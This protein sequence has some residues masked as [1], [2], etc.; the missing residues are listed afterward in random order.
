M[1]RF[2]Q[3][4]SKIMIFCNLGASKVIFAIETTLSRWMLLSI[5]RFK[6][7]ASHLSRDSSHQPRLNRPSSSNWSNELIV[8]SSSGL[9]FSLKSRLQRR[10]CLRLERIDRLK[11]LRNDWNLGELMK[12]RTNIPFTQRLFPLIKLLGVF[13][14][15]RLF[16]LKLSIVSRQ[17]RETA[18][19]LM[20][21]RRLR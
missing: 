4:E 15:Q 19:D 20:R 10:R 17:L 6:L 16:G 2:S 21:S 12:F 3:G 7:N 1:C 11:T 9:W 13:E 5:G 14:K 8:R 18:L